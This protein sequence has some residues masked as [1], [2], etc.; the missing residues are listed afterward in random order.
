MHDLLC[1]PVVYSHAPLAMF[2]LDCGHALH[3]IFEHLGETIGRKF[4]GHRTSGPFILIFL[5]HVLG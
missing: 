1:S 4:G 5:Y 3:G 2:F